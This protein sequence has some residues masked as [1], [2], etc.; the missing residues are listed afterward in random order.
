MNPNEL[1]IKMR[2]E[3]LINA[4]EGK[5]YLAILVDETDS[6]GHPLTIAG[7]IPSE[8]IPTLIELLNME[9]RMCQSP[10]NTVTR[11]ISPKLKWLV[12]NIQDIS[13]D[14]ILTTLESGIFPQD[15][16]SDK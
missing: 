11:E 9:E 13:S 5:S 7:V 15:N 4:L 12:W 16:S 2:Q 1:A 3:Q 6:N 8:T 14:V 10:D